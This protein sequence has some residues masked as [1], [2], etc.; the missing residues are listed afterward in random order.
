MSFSPRIHEPRQNPVNRRSI[1]EETTIV[2]VATEEFIFSI[3]A[4]LLCHH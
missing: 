1:V 2:V 4:F 3:C